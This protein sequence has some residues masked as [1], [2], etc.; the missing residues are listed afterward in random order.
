VSASSDR[1]EPETQHRSDEELV[2]EPVADRL[3][4]VKL[5]GLNLVDA[6]S[7][8][9][10]IEEI[11]GG[12]VRLGPD[13]EPMPDV[14][15][16]VLTPNVDIIVQLDKPDAVRERTLFE[17]AQFCLPDGQ[18]VVLASRLL[19]RPLTTRLAGSDL[20]ARLWPR[21]VADQVSTVVVASSEEVAS[22]LNSEKPNATFVI[23]PMFDGADAEA[24]ASVAEDILD[25]CRAQRP[26]LLMIG[27]GHPKD[28][29]VLGAL[30]DRWPVEMGQ[31]PVAMG[32]GGSFAMYLGLLKRA[33]V[34]LQRLSLEWFYRFC[35]EPRRLFRRY[36]IED[37][38]FIGI[39]ARERRR[40]AAS[41]IDE[42]REAR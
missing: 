2:V 3:R 16:L 7:I 34:F 25:A 11:L 4:R 30:L 8:D 19:G 24:V 38:A 40:I 12:A 22:R 27:V 29:R 5:F 18:P 37:V 9:D 26:A 1:D 10:V 33:P 21:V 17:R 42:E 31:P 13:G 20:F 36:F 39:V 35:Q 15:P 41:S 6:A 14:L 28:A 23:P 32:L